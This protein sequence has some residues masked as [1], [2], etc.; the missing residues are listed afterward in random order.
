MH[1]AILAATN[2]AKFNTTVVSKRRQ[3]INLNKHTSFYADLDPET[4]EIAS[5]F[6]E[7]I[8]VI[9]P[10]YMLGQFA[11]LNTKPR[12][13]SILAIE[14]CR[15]MVFHKKEFDHI[16]Q[17]YNLEFLERRRFL[18]TII[19]TIDDMSDENKKTQFIQYFVP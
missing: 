3:K 18:S 6:G 14:D 4:C 10:G 17:F 11:L 8:A 12:N 2:V 5:Q 7:P 9:Q 19:P 1:K 16:K 13:A 15:M